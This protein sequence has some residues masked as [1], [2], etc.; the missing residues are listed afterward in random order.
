M[1]N[2]IIF[3][4]RELHHVPVKGALL[5]APQQT[6]RPSS[7]NFWSSLIYMYIENLINQ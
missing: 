7:S 1:R 5:S 2:M 3:L 4:G 6:V